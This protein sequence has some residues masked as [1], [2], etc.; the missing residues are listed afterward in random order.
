[1]EADAVAASFSERKDHGAA[2]SEADVQRFGRY[3]GDDILRSVNAAI[4]Q[5]D[6][7]LAAQQ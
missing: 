3:R 4:S 1:V 7:K 6:A 5:F 2:W